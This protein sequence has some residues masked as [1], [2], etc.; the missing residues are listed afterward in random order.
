M[1]L[2]LLCKV[3]AQATTSQEGVPLHE[4][5]LNNQVFTRGETLNITI[6]ANVGTVQ[7][8]VYSP[9]NLFL[10]Y[11]QE[12][13]TSVTFPIDAQWRFGFW[14]V[15]AT[16]DGT[17][18]GSSF[19]VLNDGDYVNASLPYNQVHQGTNYTITDAGVNATL[20]SANRTLAITYPTIISHN[21]TATTVVHIVYMAK[22]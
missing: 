3:D 18:T 6:L 4:L 8:S 14:N 1:F 22:C 5:L 20:L 21:Q 15:T 9:D 10:S 17:Q 13:N 2:P 19:T 11:N 7:I 16:F 12:A